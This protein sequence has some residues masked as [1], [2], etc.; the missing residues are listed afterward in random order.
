[1][2]LS[3]DISRDD[4]ISKGAA[5]LESELQSQVEYE[6]ALQNDQNLSQCLQHEVRNIDILGSNLIANR[7]LPAK[8]RSNVQNYRDN[9]HKIIHG[10]AAFIEEQKFAT[11]DEA[12]NNLQ[13]APFD[14]SRLERFYHSQKSLSLSI[15]TLNVMIEIFSKVNHAILDK[16]TEVKKQSQGANLTRLYLQNAVLVYE[17]TDFVISFIE[18][19]GL[20]GM[21]DIELIKNETLEYIEETEIE[22]KGLMARSSQASR[23]ATKDIVLK[24][25]ENRNQ[26]RALARQKWSEFEKRI[27]ELKKDANAV[28]LIIPDLELIQM[29]AQSQV[30]LLHII[31]ISQIV[32]NNL[33]IVRS[34][35]IDGL[36]IA[37]LTPEDACKMLGISSAQ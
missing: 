25:I 31:A 24:D 15:E 2:S 23:Q 12:I 32:E 18:N 29:N 6:V 35:G 22:D 8:I 37:S 10:V 16:I 1:M 3:A 36:A 21:E 7:N 19:T 27:Q 33:D 14:R 26:V 34:I 30:K 17:L 4:F 9:L 20:G 11:A 28:N 5:V 13:M